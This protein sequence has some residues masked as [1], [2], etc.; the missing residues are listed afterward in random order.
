[1]Y[2]TGWILQRRVWNN[3]RC[4][5]PQKRKLDVFEKGVCL[6]VACASYGAQPRVFMLIEQ[7]T[8]KVL[9]IIGY[10][11]RLPLA[12]IVIAFKIVRRGSFGENNVFVYNLGKCLI[13]CGAFEW[14]SSI[15]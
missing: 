6:D 15:L 11:L 13:S 1:M 9:T 5:V 3:G 14:C 7:T 12:W 8:Y 10:R 4:H 2:W